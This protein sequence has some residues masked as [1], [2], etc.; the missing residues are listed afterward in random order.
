MTDSTTAA[1]TDDY[2]GTPLSQFLYTHQRLT[3]LARGPLPSAIVDEMLHTACGIAEKI[4]EAPAADWRELSKKVL[5]L[6][7]ELPY[8]PE[9]LDKICEN[10]SE[11][12]SRLSLAE[13][14]E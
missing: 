14:A 11:D 8:E 5:L 6:L 4:L 2:D 3:N 13:A 7:N 9:W 12:I 10:L 1:T